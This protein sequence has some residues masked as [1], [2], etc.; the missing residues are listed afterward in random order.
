MFGHGPLGWLA[1]LDTAHSQRL[2]SWDRTGGNRD[3]VGIEPGQSGVLADLAG[4][5]VVRHIWITA[6]SEDRH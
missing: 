2:S 5:G 3:Y 1:T 4:A 6:S